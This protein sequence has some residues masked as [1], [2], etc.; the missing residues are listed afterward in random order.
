MIKNI[1]FF[2]M[3]LHQDIKYV[4]EEVIIIVEMHQKSLSWPPFW[5]PLPPWDP[6]GGGIGPYGKLQYIY[7][8]Y[9]HEPFAQDAL[10]HQEMKIILALI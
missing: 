10:K 4:F 9:I 6:Q 7:R 1:L 8:Y 5:A 2:I 3:Y